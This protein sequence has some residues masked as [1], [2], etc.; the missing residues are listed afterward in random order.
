[1]NTR[2]FLMSLAVICLVSFML[3][4]LGFAQTRAEQPKGPPVTMTA[5]IIPDTVSGGYKLI[6]VKPHEE[7]KV[8]NVND[9][10][11]KD[12]AAKG[13]PV[14]IEGKYVRGAY[15]VFIEKINGEPYH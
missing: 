11:L 1:M 7:H 9:A 3:G 8:Q 5:K 13:E 10:I 2:K 12:L 14:K 4:H 6:R 15:M